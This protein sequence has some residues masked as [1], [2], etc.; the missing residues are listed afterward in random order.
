MPHINI[1]YFNSS[2]GLFVLASFGDKLCLCDWS[3]NPCA[4]R[5]KRRIERYLNASFKIETTSVLEEAKRQLDGYFAGN[6][7]AF[8]IPLHLVGTDFQQQVWN[9]LLN[10]PYGATISYKEIAQNIGK[11]KAVRAVAG[12]IGANGI[13]ILIPCHRVI[14]SDK[15]LTGYAGG[16]K[17]KK[18]LLQ[19]ETQIK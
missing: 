13:S 15:S 10:I 5:N 2:C 3:N 1:Q 12:A 4:E 19:I 16:L 18:M 9:E 14:G 8:T 6:R 7:K 11:P 17:A